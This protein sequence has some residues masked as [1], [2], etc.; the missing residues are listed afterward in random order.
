MTEISS[1]K[2]LLFISVLT[3]ASKQA[4]QNDNPHNERHR[5]LKQKVK[6]KLF[7]RPVVHD[8]S[9]AFI[10]LVKRWNMRWKNE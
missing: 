10:F 1:L 4:Q 8:Q 5:H 6:L 9:S 2:A 3:N 7:S